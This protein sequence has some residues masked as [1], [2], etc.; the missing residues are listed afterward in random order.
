MATWHPEI[1]ITTDPLQSRPNKWDGATG[2]TVDFWG[3]VRGLEDG[4]EL[5]GIEYEAHE[6]MARHQMEMITR[7]AQ[8]EFGLEEIVLQH[9]IGFVATG[10]ASLFLRV[11][12]AHRAAAY[13]G[14]A[15]IV[16]ELKLKVPIWKRP[17]FVRQKSGVAAK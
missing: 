10:E 15:W 4:R 5:S 9:R 6:A 16:A 8:A 11:G 14:S 1:L 13:Q 12:S 2:A 7:A 3:V 17:V